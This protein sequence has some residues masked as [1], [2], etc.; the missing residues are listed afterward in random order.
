[1]F[2]AMSAYLDM[3]YNIYV[4]NRCWQHSYLAVWFLYSDEKLSTNFG[5]P[6][7]SEDEL[8]LPGTTDE[9]LSPLASS[10][11]E[12]LSS[13][14]SEDNEKYNRKTPT[15]KTISQQ[16]SGENKLHISWMVFLNQK[17]CSLC[18]SLKTFE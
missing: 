1:M 3:L 11:D 16:E 4:Q 9:S 8:L 18:L 7:S 6:A 15:D 5:N 2:V 13:Q 10:E 17:M 14:K 12:I